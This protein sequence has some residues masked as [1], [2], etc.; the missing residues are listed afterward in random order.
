MILYSLAALLS[1]G[2]ILGVLYFA[3]GLL[4]WMNPSRS[5]WGATL[6][7]WTANHIGSAPLLLIAGIPLYT[8]FFLRLSG[9]TFA[10]LR[11]LGDT[12]QAIADGDLTA[13]VPVKSEDELGTLA[14]NLNAMADRLQHSIQEEKAAAKTKA[15]LITGVSHDL[16]TPLTSVIGFLEYMEND[17]YRDEIEL[18][19][20]IGIAYGKSLTLKKLIDDL[21]EYTR[22]TGGLPLRREPLDLRKL[23]EQLAEEFVPV[24]EG[25]GMTYEIHTGPEPVIIEGDPAELVRLYENLF[26]NATRYGY[27]GKKLDISVFMRD[28]SAVAVCANYGKPIPPQ[29]LPYLFQ[30]FYRVDKSRSR[31][32]GGS[33][34][35]LAIAKSIAELHGGYI[36][37]RSSEKR[38]EFETVFP[39]ANTNTEAET[40]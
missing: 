30:R 24:L 4:V 40:L 29:D 13:R 19:H 25:S 14:L 1:T 22:V 17:K 2:L 15:D 5:F 34:L 31:Q 23:L 32:T 9:G 38:T 36:Q 21:F 8:L 35:G 3:A 33:G 39:L 18:R 26:T 7:R 12:M 28:S 10:Y 27:E 37:A 6:I 11:R 16:R 20:Y